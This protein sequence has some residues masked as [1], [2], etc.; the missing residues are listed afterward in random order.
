MGAGGSRAQPAAGSAGASVGAARAGV[1]GASAGAR[2]AGV[3]ER[4]LWRERQPVRAAQGAAKRGARRVR[5]RGMSWWGGR[6][7]RGGGSVGAVG[8]ERG[9][10]WGEP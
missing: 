7:C 3:G 8:R 10:P 5:E 2:G 6:G 4:L 1:S 9:L